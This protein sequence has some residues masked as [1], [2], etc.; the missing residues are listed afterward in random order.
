MKRNLRNMLFPT[1]FS[2]I[3]VFLTTFCAYAR[4]TQYT[5]YGTSEADGRKAVLKLH[6]SDNGSVTGQMTVDG[7]F[8]NNVNLVRT[9]IHIRGNL[10]GVW[11]SRAGRIGG[12]WTGGDYDRR[13]RHIPGWPVSGSVSIWKQN[14]N[15]LKL[16]RTN[17]GYGYVFNFTGPNVSD[18]PNSNNNPY[19]HSNN[20]YNNSHQ[21]SH[22][23][24]HYKSLEGTWRTEWGTVRLHRNGNSFTGTYTHKNGRLSGSS[25]NSQGNEVRGTWTQSPSYR[26]PSDSGTFVFTLSPDGNSFT[27]RWKYSGSHNWDGSWSGTRQ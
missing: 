27:G 17:S 8:T 7:V 25:T 10:S 18:T 26:G 16:T 13:G 2:L 22:Q 21:N 19:N 5:Y 12:Q 9:D 3:L 23:N 20:S 14:R 1:I 24:N 11:G 6:I 4:S 15:Q